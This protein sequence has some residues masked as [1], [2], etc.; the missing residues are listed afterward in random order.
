MVVF[1][2]LEKL[3]SKMLESR[4]Q[5]LDLTANSNLSLKFLLLHQINWY[6]WQRTSLK[7]YA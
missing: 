4:F 1:K 7:P 6:V 5:L 2:F 3:K